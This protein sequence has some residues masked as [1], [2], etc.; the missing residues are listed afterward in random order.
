MI[1]TVDEIKDL[2]Q[3]TV[4]TFDDLISMLI[5]ILTDEIVEYCNNDFVVYNDFETEEYFES[6]TISFQKLQAKILDSASLFDDLNVIEGGNIKI[7]G[8]YYNDGYFTVKTKSASITLRSS[9]RLALSNI[10]A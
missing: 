6:E 5:P 2:L 7:E 8:S 4:T 9:N 3:I 10:F 1:A